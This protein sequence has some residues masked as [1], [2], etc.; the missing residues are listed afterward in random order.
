MDA[1]ML[2]VS[3]PE[4]EPQVHYKGVRLALGQLAPGGLPAHAW[5]G[6]TSEMYGENKRNTPDLLV[7]K[8]T[9]LKGEGHRV[10]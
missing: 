8:V 2:A 6:K 9:T 3:F 1:H 5:I 7:A 10:A 4:V